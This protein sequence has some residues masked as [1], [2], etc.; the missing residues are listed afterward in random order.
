MTHLLRHHV[1]PSTSTRSSEDDENIEDIVATT[2]HLSP[3]LMWHLVWPNITRSLNLYDV[4]YYDEIKL[5][6]RAC[7]CGS[8]IIWY[9]IVLSGDRHCPRNIHP[10]CHWIISWLSLALWK[11][12]ATRR[13]LSPQIATLP[14]LVFWPPPSFDVT[15]EITTKIFIWISALKMSLPDGHNNDC[16]FDV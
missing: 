12:R 16:R 3:D 11:V 4:R 14:K 1:R 10:F 9:I 2:V 15:L 8:S 5:V 6:G 13:L 7:I